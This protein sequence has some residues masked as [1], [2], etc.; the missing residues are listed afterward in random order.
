M[1][2][3]IQRLPTVGLTSSDFDEAIRQSLSAPKMTSDDE[4][5]T[6]VPLQDDWSEVLVLEVED[7]PETRVSEDGL[8]PVGADLS[9]IVELRD[10]WGFEVERPHEDVEEE[11]R[12]KSVDRWCFGGRVAWPTCTAGRSFF[13]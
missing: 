7:T 5:A 10:E 1:S 6:R 11:L 3:K 8:K 13:H 12:G 4:W 9:E 2:L